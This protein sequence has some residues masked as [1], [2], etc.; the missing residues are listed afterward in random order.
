MNT[1]QIEQIN[2]T[3]IRNAHSLNFKEKNLLL[4]NP[5]KYVATQKTEYEIVIFTET[6][7]RRDECVELLRTMVKNIVHK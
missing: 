4:G 2:Y 1:F 6:I 5:N 3:L 7:G